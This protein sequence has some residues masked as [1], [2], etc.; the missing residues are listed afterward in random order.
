MDGWSGGYF[1]TLV[2]PDL[3]IGH[4]VDDAVV[5]G[6]H[7]PHDVGGG[8]DGQGQGDHQPQHDVEHHCVVEVVFVGQVERAVGVTL[9]TTTDTYGKMLYIR[10]EQ[11]D[12]S[13]Y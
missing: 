1:W 9:K 12:T 7:V 10:K 8:D 13:E 11:W 5:A 2:H 4:A 3:L 6:V